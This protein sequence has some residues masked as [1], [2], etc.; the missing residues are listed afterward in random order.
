MKNFI[1]VDG[2]STFIKSEGH[3]NFG[4]TIVGKP[5]GT[6]GTDV[7]MTEDKGGG[8]N[9]IKVTRKTTV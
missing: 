7:G 5:Y 6:P 9:C 1:S 4:Q 2:T 3:G 8:V